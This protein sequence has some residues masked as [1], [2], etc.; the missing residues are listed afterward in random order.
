MKRKNCVGYLAY[1]YIVTNIFN[2][3]PFLARRDLGPQ[4]LLHLPQSLPCL[5]LTHA[6]RC[7]VKGLMF[8]LFL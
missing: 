2:K 1:Y 4:E 6:F 7:Y 5:A 8:T 3:C